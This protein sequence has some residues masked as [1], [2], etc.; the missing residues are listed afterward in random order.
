MIRQGTNKPIVMN[1]IVAP[2]D[3][4]VTLHNE[5]EVL[6]RWDVTDMTQ[7]ETGLIWTAPVEQAESKGWEEGPCEIEI[8]WVPSEGDKAGIVQKHVIR[9]TI[10]HTTDGTE[11]QVDVE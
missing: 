2:T 4:V 1:F 9:E 6:K 3:I 11:L 10:E 7:D 8:R 5:I